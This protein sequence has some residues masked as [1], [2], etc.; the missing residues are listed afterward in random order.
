MLLSA[1]I[2]SDCRES[3]GLVLDAV[4]DGFKLEVAIAVTRCTE[5]YGER[6]AN[7]PGVIAAVRRGNQST[8]PGTAMIKAKTATC[9]PT[10]GKAPR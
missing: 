10:K 4:T 3:L 9:K 2:T 1:A 8:N 5:L 7:G 6:Q